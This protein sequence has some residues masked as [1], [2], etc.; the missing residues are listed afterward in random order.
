MVDGNRF[1]INKFVLSADGIR[2]RLPVIKR[3]RLEIRPEDR[4]RYRRGE[5]VEPVHPIIFY[6]DRQFPKMYQKCIIEAVREWRPAFE[7]A[8]LKCH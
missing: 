8:G 2:S 1:E 3:W 6:V 5:L 4:E 7:Q